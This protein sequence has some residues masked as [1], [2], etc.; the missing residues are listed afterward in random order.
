MLLHDPDAYDLDEGL[1]L[2]LP[3]LASL[4]SAGLADEVGVG[5][6]SVH[7]AVRAIAEGDIDVVMIAGRYTL[8]EQSA[9]EALLPLAANRGVR[10]IAAAVFNSGLLAAKDPHQA[11]YNYSTVPDSIAEKSRRLQEL[12]TTFGV[13]MT[14]AALQFPLRHRA[15]D[16]VVVGTARASAIRE[17]I[18]SLRVT[19]PDEF[20]DALSALA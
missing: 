7:A 11:H 3:A 12:C 20:W 9:A 19:I 8:L 1:R 18:E 14:A 2:G 4:R 13:P 10:V 5:V 17:N 15:V 16:S 6:N